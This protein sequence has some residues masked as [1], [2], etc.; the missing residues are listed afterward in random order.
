MAV[1]AKGG[2]FMASIGA[3][4]TRVRKTFKTESEGPMGVASRCCQRGSEGSP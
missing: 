1:Y 4:D 2:K 3:V